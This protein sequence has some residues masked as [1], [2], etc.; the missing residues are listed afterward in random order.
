MMIYFTHIHTRDG[1]APGRLEVGP[2]LRAC[3]ELFSQ[4]SS[5][6]AHITIS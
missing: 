6:A 4:F 5:P 2:P 3:R 1:A